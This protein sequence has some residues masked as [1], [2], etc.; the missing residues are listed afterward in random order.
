M[1]DPLCGAMRLS[2]DRS[3]IPE[4]AGVEADGPARDVGF[5]RSLVDCGLCAGRTPADGA[6]DHPVLADLVA[7][8]AGQPE[9]VE[10][11][12]PPVVPAGRANDGFDKASRDKAR[13]M[14]K[15]RL[16]VES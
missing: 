3:S 14:M 10:D 2:R 13:C 8:A 6:F 1:L 9:A 4:I 7:D 12:V 15:L 11:V 5:D 16:E